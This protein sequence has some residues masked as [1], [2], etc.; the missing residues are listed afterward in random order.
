MS[1]VVNGL[2]YQMVL[3]DSTSVVPGTNMQVAT[4]DLRVHTFLERYEPEGGN[5]YVEDSGGRVHVTSWDTPT[6]RVD[7]MN[8]SQFRARFRGAVEDAWNGKL[9]LIADRPYGVYHR[10]DGHL[11]QPAVACK[12]SIVLVSRV[13]HAKLH[14]RCVKRHDDETFHRSSMQ[15]SWCFRWVGGIFGMA[16]GHIDDGDVLQS[17]DQI[18]MPHELGHYIGLPHVA[19]D[20]NEDACYGPPG[21]YQ[22]TDMMG[23][24]MRI[25]TWHCRPWRDAMR[26]FNRARWSPALTPVIRDLGP[27][28]QAPRARLGA[29]G[30]PPPPDGGI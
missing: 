9:F 15:S 10:E 27:E 17:G 23:R 29:G 4:L 11:F 28:Y 6:T 21:S 22:A 20:G 26:N 30:M 12:L 25:D 2:S 18:A 16:G 24:G 5:G 8:F 19:C 13:E 14:A 7:D 1:R 3:S